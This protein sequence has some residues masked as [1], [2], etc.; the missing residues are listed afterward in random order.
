MVIACIRLTSYCLDGTAVPRT[1][2][3]AFEPGGRRFDSFRARQSFQMVTPLS[4]SCEWRRCPFGA[5]TV[6]ISDL[7]RCECWPFFAAQGEW[8]LFPKPAARASDF[9]ARRQVSECD[10]SFIRGPTLQRPVRTM[11]I[12]VVLPSDQ[13][14]LVREPERIANKHLRGSRR[15]LNQLLQDYGNNRK[16][17][18]AEILCSPHHRSLRA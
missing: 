15:L 9:L 8:R 14:F 5:Q 16:I 17:C 2:R 12:V 1:R 18:L 10:Q 6:P 7:V 4:L 11:T 13:F 3:R